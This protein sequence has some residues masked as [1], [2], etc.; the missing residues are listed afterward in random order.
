MNPGAGGPVGG[1][2]MINNGSTAPRNDG[3]LNHIPENMIINLNT[4]IYDYFLKRGYYDCARALVQDESIKLNTDP[5]TKTSPGHRRDGDINGIDGDAM[6]TD[7]KDGERLKIPD[8]L[9]RPSLPSESQQSSFLL[10]WFSLFWDF[11]WAQRKKGNSND[12]RQYLQH[13]QNIMRMREQQQNHMLRQPM[14]PGQMGQLN[15]MRRPGMIPNLQKTVLQNNT[16]GLSQ[17]QIAHLKNQQQQVHMMQHMQ[18]EHSDIDMNGHRPQSPSSAE[19]APSPPKRPRL[20][21]GPMNGQQQLAP[22][23]RGQGQVMPGQPNQPALLM[24]NG[25]ARTMNPGQ[26]PAFQQQGGPAG[27]QQKSIQ[28]YA[29]N[30]ALHHSRSALNN[31]GMPNGLMNPGVMPNQTDLVPMPDGQGMYPMSADFYAANGQIV[32][33]RTGMQTPGGQHGNHA[34]QDY[35]MQL[36]LL[37]QQNKRRL[38]MA[39][40][41]QDSM[42]RVDGQPPMPGQQALPPGTSPQGSRAG[43]S[44]N[45]NDQM[46]RG[47]PKIP[48]TGLPGSPSAVDAMAQGRGSP[49]SMN[50]TG[51]MPSDMSSSFFVKGMEGMAGPNG[52]RPPSSNPAFSGPQMVQPIP[53]GAAN[54][55]PNGGWQ[56]GPQGQP[57]VPQQQ[58][59]NQPQPT[60]TPQ[61]RGAMPPP[62]APPAPGA[63]AGRTQP[64]SPQTGAAPPTPQQANKAAPK[65]KDTKD[66]KKR[67]KKASTAAANSNTAATPSSETE[68]PP[69]PT[70]STPI[71]PQHPN[72][73]NKTGANAATSA[74]QQ[75]TSAP[76]PQPMVQQP[77]DQTFPEIPIPDTAAFNL[78]FT[79]LEN[80]DI[81][82]NFDFDTFLNTDA[83]ATGFGFDPSISYPTDGVET[84]AGDGL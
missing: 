16:G 51:Q 50:F 18:R 53:A 72:S 44:P 66:V 5:N 54:R 58:P 17:Q 79:T 60:G 40:Q 67:I 78:D 35:Q 83:D 23:G 56:P 36:M 68:P 64:A 75:P 81:L 30:L 3:N 41:E 39:R 48:Q 49:A 21:G 15:N 52:M 19:N 82:E 13:H 38:M 6:M 2:P 77:P 28:V 43:T 57:M 37:E 1:V 12:V 8:D 22:N 31:Q 4:Y 46:K 61:E 20:E 69:T 55:V 25:M 7:G 34:L 71:T 29:H 84:G 65:K 63:V 62:Q 9:P 76:A 73:F 33:G 14:M 10:D 59:T 26:F 24:Q 32:Q 74:P 11:F 45:P 70:P 42:T 47:T 27:Q 80:P